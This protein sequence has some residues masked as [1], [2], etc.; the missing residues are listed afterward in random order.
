MFA[1]TL[2]LTIGASAKVLNRVNQDAGGSEYTLSSATESISMKIRH[3]IDKIDGDGIVMKRHNVFVERIVF[4]TATALMQ[5]YTATA[6]FRH[7]RFDDPNG[8]A[9]VMKAL[10]AFLAATTNA[11]DLAAGVN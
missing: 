6:T 9:D 11:A 2:T 7:G 10:A 8:S 5:K 1:N 4:P 3:S